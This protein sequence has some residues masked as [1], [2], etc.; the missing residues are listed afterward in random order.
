MLT[1]GYYD[2]T[3]RTELPGRELGALEQR[4][5]LFAETGLTE[6]AGA[7]SDPSL[8]GAAKSRNDSRNIL[9][10]TNR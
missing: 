9:E 10:I 2:S 7:G 4:G 6:T 8:E 1:P 5:V 3:E